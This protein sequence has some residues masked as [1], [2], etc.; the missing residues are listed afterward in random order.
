MEKKEQNTI[1]NFIASC[2]EFTA[3]KFLFA[4]SKLLILLTE[5]ENSEDLKQLFEEC[6]Q[7]FN[8]SLEFT[9]AFVK[10][11]TKL[12]TFT[13]PEELDKFLALFYGVLKEIRDG[14]Y[15]F[16]EFVSKYFSFDEKLP[17]TQTFAREVI[18]PLKETIAKYFEVDENNAV[19][20]NEPMQESHKE[21]LQ[22]E[23]PV[24]DDSQNK[25]EEIFVS[26]Q[27]LVQNMIFMTRQ[28]KISKKR[29]SDLLFMLS[30]LM[31]AC[32]KKDIEVVCV[33]IVALK[34][35]TPIFSKIRFIVSELEKIVTN[36]EC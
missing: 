23:E 31:S 8:Y 17:P 33:L 13:R 35:I 20:Y 21:S 26:V 12:G 22:I 30:E 10:M 14:K 25:L 27:E 15:E 7:D 1:L 6:E 34:Y 11:P 29:K 16:N 19:H 18:K 9:K 36:Q 3:G 5:I 24:Q 28:S 32:E 2:N 4:S